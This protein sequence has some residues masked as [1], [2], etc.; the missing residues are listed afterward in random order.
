MS[1]RYKAPNCFYFFKK[2][3]FIE[4]NKK[5]YH[6]YFREFLKKC[7]IMSLSVTVVI[8]AGQFI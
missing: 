7:E 5:N 3:E 6:E 2:H 4:V 8:T 1:G